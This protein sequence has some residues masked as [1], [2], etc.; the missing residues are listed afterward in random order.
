MAVWDTRIMLVTSHCYLMV[1]GLGDTF[2]SHKV[3]TDQP[4]VISQ[5]LFLFQSQKNQINQLTFLLEL[6]ENDA[7]IFCL[8]CSSLQYCVYQHTIPDWKELRTSALIYGFIEITLNEPGKLKIKISL[9][10]RRNWLIDWNWFHWKIN[11]NTNS[12]TTCCPSK[13]CIHSEQPSS[14][15]AWTRHC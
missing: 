13:S 4:Y 2:I 15:R 6:L 10:L 5:F 14:N 8:L 7:K 12:F 9:K 1:G 11:T 3:T